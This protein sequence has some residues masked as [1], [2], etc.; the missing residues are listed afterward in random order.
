MLA[1]RRIYSIISGQGKTH[2]F[3]LLR[4]QHYLLHQGMEATAEVMESTLFE[5][6]VGSM[7]PVKLWIKLK[8]AD[9]TYI[10]IHT[11][12]LVTLNHIPFT[13]QSLRIMYAPKDLSAI[14]ILN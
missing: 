5:E 10:Y 1:I 13:G 6:K 9:G 2:K 8:K 12:T 4:Q 3:H 11:N 7:F 14:L